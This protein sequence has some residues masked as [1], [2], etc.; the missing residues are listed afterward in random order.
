MVVMTNDILGE[1]AHKMDHH[2]N[3]MIFCEVEA[4][5]GPYLVINNLVINNLVVDTPVTFTCQVA[6]AYLA[7]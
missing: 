7:T 2:D 6:F 3:D 5:N 1:V 4:L